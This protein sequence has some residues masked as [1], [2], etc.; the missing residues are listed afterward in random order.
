MFIQQ[1]HDVNLRVGFDVDRLASVNVELEQSAH[2]IDLMKAD[3][4]VKRS[5]A[6]V[7]DRILI[8]AVKS[9]QHQA[10]ARVASPRCDMQR[11]LTF[12]CEKKD[13]VM[14]QQRHFQN[15]SRRKH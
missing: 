14:K 3:C 11:R 4:Y 6:F 2:T 9:T 12:F 5:F 1:L 15:K 8:D 10:R 13:S 7:V